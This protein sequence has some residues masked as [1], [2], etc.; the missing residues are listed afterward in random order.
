MQSS[1]PGPLPIRP[2][3]MSSSPLLLLLLALCS[4]MSA[5]TSA[6]LVQQ[7]ATAAAPAQS[8]LAQSGMA[9]PTDLLCPMKVPVGSEAPGSPSM[10]NVSC[11]PYGTLQCIG[12]GGGCHC[13]GNVTGGHCER[14]ASGYYAANGRADG[15]APC[16]CPAGRVRSHA[17]GSGVECDA[18]TGQCACT[19]P[20]QGVRCEICAVGYRPTPVTIVGSPGDSCVP[21]SCDAVGTTT[22][23]GSSP[24]A[25]MTSPCHV[26]TG[27]CPCRRG[28]QGLGCQDCAPGFHRS[29][30]GGVCTACNCYVAGSTNITCPSIAQSPAGS[31]SQSPAVTVGQCS[32]KP[33]Y[34]GGQCNV[35]TEVNHYL[36]A[37]GCQRFR[38]ES[39]SSSFVARNV[40]LTPGL[41]IG[42]DYREYN[43]LKIS[44]NGVISFG[45]SAL[46][47]E[48]ANKTRLQSSLPILAPYW[49]NLETVGLGQ[50]RVSFVSRSSNLQRLQVIRSQLMQLGSDTDF[51]P[52]K[53]IVLEWR[54]IQSASNASRRNNFQVTIAGD[55]CQS[56]AIF[57]YSDGGVFATTPPA[58]VGT[59]MSQHVASG[60]DGI[61]DAVQ[62]QSV[63]YAL[64]PGCKVSLR[65]GQTCTL[66]TPLSR[67][68]DTATA[69]FIECPG[70]LSLARNV[71]HFQDYK[72]TTL[73][74]AAEN[75]LR[76]RPVSER[77]TI[78]C[79]DS[80]SNG[81]GLITTGVAAAYVA[82]ETRDE[83]RLASCWHGN[84]LAHF[85]HHRRSAAATAMRTEFFLVHAVDGTAVTWYRPTLTYFFHRVGEFR[86][87]ELKTDLFD[88]THRISVWGRYVQNATMATTGHGGDGP[89]FTYLERVA[90]TLSDN[91]P[92]S[93]TVTL[94]IFVSGEK[95]GVSDSNRE[96]PVSWLGTGHYSDVIHY[97]NDLL[98]IRSGSATLN[99][100]LTKVAGA[101]AFMTVYLQAP[102]TATIL[103]GFT[104][105][106]NVRHSASSQN[107][108]RLT[109]H[110]VQS[111]RATLTTSPF[112]YTPSANYTVLN[113]N[114]NATSAAELNLTSIADSST[115]TAIRS[116]CS[117][118]DADF[119]T[120]L[121]LY[122][123]Y[124]STSGYAPATAVGQLLRSAR[125]VANSLAVLAPII[126]F[127]TQVASLSS[128]TSI[129]VSAVPL[130]SATIA[131]QIT[132]N[133]TGPGARFVTTATTST[134]ISYAP[135]DLG[136]LVVTAT[137]VDSNGV[138]VTTTVP[139]AVC[140]CASSTTG[141]CHAS[142]FVRPFAVLP[143]TCHAGLEGA[144]CN[145]TIDP[146]SPRPCSDRRTCTKN[147][148][149]ASCSADC[150]QGFRSNS[151]ES[152]V[153]VNECVVGT[154]TI[155][156]DA[157]CSRGNETCRD[158]VGSYV[159]D[160]ASGFV[161]T[162]VGGGCMDIDECA[163][164]TAVA[165]SCTSPVAVCNNTVGSYSCS[166]RYG[167]NGT[168]VESTGGCYE[169]NLCTTNLHAC[170]AYTEC[171]HQTGIATHVCIC[172]DGLP[173]DAQKRCHPAPT[174][175][176]PVQ[177]P[178]LYL[179]RHGGLSLTCI[180]AGVVSGEI[181][182]TGPTGIIGK[183]I[184]SSSVTLHQ[185][186]MSYSILSLSGHSATSAIG[187]YSCTARN[188]RLSST[189][190][191]GVI[192]V[193]TPPPTTQPPPTTAAPTTTG[194]LTTSTSDAP[195]PAEHT[196]SSNNLTNGGAIPSS[197][198][199]S[200]A[201]TV[202]D[203]ATADS[204][205]VVPGNK[206]AGAGSGSGSG[207]A[208]LYVA[209]VFVVMFVLAAT[210]LAW[211]FA[212]QRNSSS[213]AGLLQRGAP[214]GSGRGRGILKR[215]SSTLPLSARASN[216]ALFRPAT[217]A[218]TD[219][220][221][222][223]PP[224]LSLSSSRPTGSSSSN[225][226]NGG[227]N[228][229][230]GGRQSPAEVV[231]VR[232]ASS[233]CTYFTVEEVSATLNQLDEPHPLLTS[234][235]SGGR[236]PSPAVEQQRQNRARHYST[237][238]AC[239]TLSSTQA[240]AL[241]AGGSDI[242]GSG[243][244]GGGVREDT[245]LT[246]TSGS[247]LYADSPGDGMH[248]GGGTVLTMATSDPVNNGNRH[249]NGGAGAS[250]H[251]PQDYRA[252]AMFVSEP[253]AATTAD[254]DGGVEY[255]T[256]GGGGVEYATT[257][258]GGGDYAYAAEDGLRLAR[259]KPAAGASSSQSSPGSGMQGNSPAAAATA[260]QRKAKAAKERSPTLPPPYVS[261][262]RPVADTGSVSSDAT[263]TMSD[264]EDPM[265]TSRDLHVGMT[266]V[267]DHRRLS[268]LSSV[269]DNLYEMDEEDRTAWS[270]TSS[271]PA[272]AK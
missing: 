233:S 88:Y 185:L 136:A 183:T 166:C 173:P 69:Q 182:W 161:R 245:L 70:S 17:G 220:A 243:G 121:V 20:Y 155:P 144:M 214:A 143:C 188:S 108:E 167:Y 123:V 35:C 73:G 163:N 124:N 33:G 196:S 148:L 87:A 38:Y 176:R 200:A 43:S 152:C 64:T 76:S 263:A 111:N 50:V 103:D 10:R 272:R 40:H 177:R 229:G 187:N 99:V 45:D 94:E 199:S 210:G 14:C 206:A 208:Y 204:A 98:Q 106:L 242:E 205:G 63:L 109:S 238:T 67:E 83:S 107:P 261:P 172:Q 91:R 37:T 175:L 271:P 179:S 28:Y 9:V 259:S 256:T 61:M 146:C 218:D 48:I 65:E 92:M 139:V 46:D 24:T 133:V 113:P 231:S 246:S 51:L 222:K 189:A 260:Q 186:D 26:Q 101:R 19:P 145:E 4:T 23:A 235:R 95:L 52:T 134:G 171:R 117:D 228:T 93:I 135:M 59:S 29:T 215:L 232:P 11:N 47:L 255:A 257:V 227:P 49:T 30:V 5:G 84:N 211:S 27:Q 7:A 122:A 170:P 96:L 153:N 197:V 266:S 89:Q 81:G 174:L 32:C 128:T 191:F 125:L 130:N 169:I 213:M 192:A 181:A 66:L 132:F 53:A 2:M 267:G 217:A 244:V 216:D 6:G 268:A 202:V 195:S 31:S 162:T 16:S 165:T 42:S 178:T 239:S 127:T 12:D 62:G 119:R 126:T 184:S 212:K 168:G 60:T 149:Q 120:C 265:E 112:T 226:S 164:S 156:A 221:N 147:G 201:A 86:L 44:L 219:A 269:E 237:S 131:G 97:A 34:T 158:T 25:T 75:C 1:T 56:Y 72:R 207:S 247:N 240:A 254:G 249:A 193:P 36:S 8:S 248:A 180:F 118:T 100:T 194:L 13:R 190:W 137:A 258:G 39:I 115:Q 78:C 241:Q 234:K 21:C 18:R 154:G 71:W 141:T 262:Q 159:C 58:L 270:T 209:I 15:C 129:T 41:R 138:N 85:F 68:V 77:A 54:G 223:R 157:V 110:M 225:G 250:R 264:Y 198:A 114:T 252:P 80:D 104:G 224:T 140:G 3:P 253:A 251:Q 116:L 79:Y 142:A 150:I 57:D 236:T 55:V 203:T 151:T 160:C 22:T 74:P 82:Y 90:V 102:K 105:L 230:G